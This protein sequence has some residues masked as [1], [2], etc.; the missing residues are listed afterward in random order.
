MSETGDETQA[1]EPAGDETGDDA[2]VEAEYNQQLDSDVN[3]DGEPEA[4]PEPL[5][6]DDG[7]P[8][9]DAETARVLTE[10][11]LARRSDALARENVRHAK[12]V[13]E[14]MEDDLADLIPC[15]VCM[16]GIAGWVYLPEVQ[17]LPAE[18]IAR[19]RQVIGLPDYST[20]AAAPDAT[21][22]PECNG[23]GEVTTGSHV[24]GYEVKTC[25]RCRKQGWI[26]VGEPAQFETV[27]RETGEIVTGPTVYTGDAADP[28]IA[29]LRERGFTVI[30]PLPTPAV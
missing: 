4:A 17:Q 25:R 7:E 13:G 10:R 20:F 1:V 8:G 12:R 2:A 26:Q 16:D 21:M 19:I 18:A 14:L 29:H 15:P 6:G 24:P 5:T 3:E 11:A 30:P 23:L 28:E 22:C 27:D 9:D